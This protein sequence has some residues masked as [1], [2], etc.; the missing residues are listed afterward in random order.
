MRLP[1]EGTPFV[2]P[3]C[4]VEKRGELPNLGAAPFRLVVDPAA[5]RD[6][7]VWGIFRIEDS[8]RTEY[9]ETD[10]LHL[11]RDSVLAQ[12]LHKLTHA[13]ENVVNPGLLKDSEDPLVRRIGSTFC[14]RVANCRGVI[15]GECWALG[16]KGVQEAIEVSLKDYEA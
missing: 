14:E 12:K 13:E 16:A 2:P 15:D 5:G 9:V 7:D 4:P 8:D 1:P 6:T 11:P 3:L 10:A